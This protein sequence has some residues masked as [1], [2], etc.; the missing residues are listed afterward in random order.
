MHCP[1]SIA[2]VGREKG[3]GSS[4]WGQTNDG[5]REKEKGRRSAK[6]RSGGIIPFSLLRCE[7]KRRFRYVVKPSKPRVS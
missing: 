5:Y 3:T 4:P 1:I 7:L 2:S 6:V